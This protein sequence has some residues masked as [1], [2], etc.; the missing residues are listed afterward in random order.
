MLRG[1][2]VRVCIGVRL[3]LGFAHFRG[4]ASGAFSR[5]GCR[6]EEWQEALT[7]GVGAMGS[8]ESWGYGN[9]GRKRDAVCLR[10]GLEEE[11]P[12]ASM[13]ASGLR[14][15][16][17]GSSMDASRGGGSPLAARREGAAPKRAAERRRA[18]RRGRTRRN[19]AEGGE[20]WMRAKSGMDALTTGRAPGKRRQRTRAE[21]GQNGRE[22]ELREATRSGH[23]RRKGVVFPRSGER[24][25]RRPQPRGTLHRTRKPRAR[26]RARRGRT[27]FHSRTTTRRAGVHRAKD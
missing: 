23:G 24:D 7:A 10:A 15:P 18:E 1:S 25:R 8:D 4:A 21:S 14:T 9:A 20:H 5:H 12:H 2:G 19:T 26:P 11:N 16:P 6:G 17:L 22:R 13:D 3:S 27:G